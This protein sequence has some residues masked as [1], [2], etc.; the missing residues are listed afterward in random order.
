[1][2]KVK[3]TTK[4]IMS[5]IIVCLFTMFGFEVAYNH[6]MYKDYAELY[7]EY[8]KLENR[9]DHAIKSTIQVQKFVLQEHGY[10]TNI[11]N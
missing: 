9:V 5:C 10:T 6:L 4:F 3:I 8:I 11:E 7:D 2:K 1:M